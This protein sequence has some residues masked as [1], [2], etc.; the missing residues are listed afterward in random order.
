[1]MGPARGNQT[2]AARMAGY[3]GD[4]RQLAVQGSVNVRNPQIQRMVAGMLDKL[5]EPSLRRLEEALDATRRRA[6]LTKEGDVRYG[7]PEPYHQVRTATANKILD[8]HERSLL[9]PFATASHADLARYAFIARADKIRAIFTKGTAEGL[10]HP[11]DRVD[12]DGHPV[13]ITLEESPGVQFV[14]ENLH[15]VTRQK[16]DDGGQTAEGKV[17]FDN[18]YFAHVNL[19]SPDA[20]GLCVAHVIGTKKVERFDDK[21]YKTKE[22]ELPIIRVDLIARIVPPGG[23]EIDI[24]RIR[25]LFYQM[26]ER[27]N[28]EFGMISFDILGSGEWVHTMQGALN[29]D[30]WSADSTPTAYEMLK[31]ATYDERILCYEMPKLEEEL[32]KLECTGTKVDH[33]SVTG[34]SKVLADCLAMVVYHCEETESMD[35]E[36]LKDHPEEVAE[37]RDWTMRSKP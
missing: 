6:F 29:C 37:I 16:G 13:D 20:A 27:F 14:P 4:D 35:R 26:K 24:A 7:D 32:A 10:K 3:R 15:W 1:L 18:M 33:P 36:W 30:V 2:L 28:I 34:S 31:A 9:N 25:G 19:L 21:T 5:V 17:L 22:E 8:R 12:A 23:G 11:L